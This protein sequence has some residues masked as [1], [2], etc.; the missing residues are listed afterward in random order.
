MD[1]QDYRPDPE[2]ILEK[3]KDEEEKET[4]KLKIFFGYAAGVGKTYA[5]LDEAKDRYNMGTD[6]LVG[7]AEPHER[8]ETL[9]FLEGLPVLPPKIIPYKSMELKEF[10]LDEALKR[11]PRLILVDELAHTNAAGSRNRKRYQD[12]EELLNAG[13]DVYTTVN[14][15]H[16]ESLNNVVEDVTRI[17]VRETVPDYIFDRADMVKVID[18]EPEELLHR[19]KEGKVYRE[20]RAKTAMNNFFTVENLKVLREIALRKAT[21]RISNEN[22]NERVMQEKMASTKFLVCIGASPSSAKCLRWTARAAEAF[23]AHWIA[24]YVEEEDMPASEQK[25]AIRENMELAEK[26]G[27]EVTT[28]NGHDIAETI[29]EYARLSGITNIVVG[30]SRNKKTIKSLFEMDFEDKLISLLPQIEVHIIP[31]SALT[32]RFKAKGRLIFL[33]PHLSFKGSDMIK[34]AGILLISL[35]LC[36]GLQTLNFGEQ[37]VIMV[38]ILSVLIVSRITE[39]YFYGVFGS[40]VSVLLFNF[41]FTEPYFTFN[42]IGNGY[43]LT[44]LIM[45]LVALITSALTV[46]IK[47]QARLAVEREHRTEVMYEINKKLLATRETENI[48]SLV[49]DYA[50]KLF[51]R[52]VILYTINDKAEMNGGFLQSEEEEDASFMRSDDEKAVAHWVFVNQKRAGAG[53]DTLM[54]AGAY[55]QPVLFQGNVLAVIGLS[56]KKGNLDHNNRLF[57]RM[58]AP[59]VAMALERQRLSDEQRNIL[60]E[61]EKEKMRSNLLRAISHDLRTPLTGILGASSAILE[62]EGTLNAETNH[63]L[64]VNIREDSQWLIRMVENLLSVT[65]IKEGTMNVTKTLEA[66]EEVIAEAVGRIRIRYPGRNILVKVPEELLEVPMDGTLIAQVI[67]N[68]L[69][70]A[71]KHSKEDAFIEIHLEKQEKWAVFEVLDNGRGILKEDVPYIFDSYMPG[72]DKPLDSSRGMGIGLSICMSIIKAHNGRMEAENRSGGGAAFRFYLPVEEN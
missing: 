54:G 12:V 63:Q 24:V 67:I 46:R 29:A 36:E 39:G 14:V 57:L 19:L 2:A 27:A 47:T 22:Q 43:P 69:E 51:G 35:L 42:A 56:C 6:V 44:F 65:R 21:E 7:Y 41:F 23:H 49:L 9:R 26:L 5:M 8:P 50:V 38:F 53:T 28:L 4:G 31:D 66:G 1:N 58:I 18:I 71:I 40:I 45:L 60:V 15:Q 34:M 17:T 70:N 10:D 62:N 52:S 16:L 68:L 72:G 64:V 55:Y 3:I 37:N 11:K 13:I 25:Q 33:K 59:L 30:K 32:R 48:V 61:T 20:E